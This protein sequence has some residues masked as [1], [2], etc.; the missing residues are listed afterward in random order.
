MH[1]IKLDLNIRWLIIGKKVVEG[2]LRAQGAYTVCDVKLEQRN[3]FA[4]IR[5]RNGVL[6]SCE[7]RTG[8]RNTHGK[9]KP[10]GSFMAISVPDPSSILFLGVWG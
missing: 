10:P 8:K 2:L 6:A 7:L 1:A 9:Y 3:A 4:G 5:S